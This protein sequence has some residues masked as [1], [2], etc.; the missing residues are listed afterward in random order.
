LASE[1]PGAFFA[2][3]E[4]PSVT[5]AP[6]EAMTRGGVNADLMADEHE[7][8][9]KGEMWAGGAAPRNAEDTGCHNKWREGEGGGE[10]GGA[11]DE[12]PKRV[13]L[14]APEENAAGGASGEPCGC[15]GE[16]V[17]AAD[18]KPKR[19]RLMAPEENAADGASEC[20]MHCGVCEDHLMTACCVLIDVTARCDQGCPWCFAHAGEGDADEPSLA[21]IGRWYDRL[22]ELGEERPFNIQ[23]SGGEPAVRDDLPEI[24]ALGRAKGFEYIQ[25]NTNGRRLG[26][27]DAA[28]YGRQLRSVEAAGYGGAEVG[29]AYAQRLA[30]AGLTT[31]FMQFDG[32][33]DAVYRELRG[34][35]LL[36][37]KLRAIENCAKV[38]L[39]VTLVP[40]IVKGVNI[41]EPSSDVHVGEI[42]GIVD[43][44]LAN[45]GTVKG[46]HFQPASFFGR[47]PSQTESS[48]ARTEL[49]PGRITMFAVMS[50]IERQTN[51]RIKGADLL[52]ITTGHPLCCFCA[53]FLRDPDGRLAPTATDAQRE[54]GMACCDSA[55]PDDAQSCCTPT[56]DPL[57][58]IRRDRDF[59]LNKWAGGEQRPAGQP[60]TIAPPARQAQ[61][62]LEPAMP[63]PC[64]PASERP[65]TEQP[66]TAP[67]TQPDS[68]AAMSFDEAISWFRR[69]MFTISGMAFMDSS[70]LDAE[71][72]KRCRVQYYTPDDRLIPFCAYNTKYRVS[73]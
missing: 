54:S 24:V 36:D 73:R 48:A 68:G 19:V 47:H 38:G 57:E 12:K 64:P 23:I 34:E 2:Y 37:A 21:E 7:D 35:P 46:I 9:A 11:A 26:A 49:H 42:G 27:E 69:N 65:N 50:E 5:V 1:D 14:M 33:T 61:K 39:P 10:G 4:R 40:T 41:F 70:N 67:Q 53:N 15:D 62:H 44:M 8:G 59:V 3:M 22:T 58:I 56:Q 18:E 16:G 71:R 60:A 66:A 17:G 13:R 28:G 6:R 43:F 52:P 31:V 51:G 55:G 45:L 32:V 20:P 29:E 72:L 30:D 63:A 25:L